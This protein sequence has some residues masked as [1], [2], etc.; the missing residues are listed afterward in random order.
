MRMQMV[1]QHR[2]VHADNKSALTASTVICIFAIPQPVGQS[3]P[4]LEGERSGRRP[5]QGR[6]CT[7]QQTGGTHAVTPEMYS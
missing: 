7:V 6:A 3:G 5:H 1:P 4:G 2:M